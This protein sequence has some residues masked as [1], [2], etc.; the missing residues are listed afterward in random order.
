MRYRSRNLFKSH[1][2]REYAHMVRKTMKM[3]VA[4]LIAAFAL[5]SMAEA[6]APKKAVRHRA[7]HSS[8]VVSGAT[9]TAGRKPAAKKKAAAARSR[10]RVTANRVAQKPAVKK[11]TAKR[12]PTTK[13]R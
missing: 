13:P 6:A 10:T 8:R 12:R 7:K 9:G 4:A 2:V 1:P 11:A 5:S 3:L